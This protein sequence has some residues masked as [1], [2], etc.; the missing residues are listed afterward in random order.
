[1]PSKRRG[2]TL[3][4]YEGG[5]LLFFLLVIL[6][7]GGFVAVVFQF[8]RGADRPAAS[9]RPGVLSE[10]EIPGTEACMF[11]LGTKISP[12][13]RRYVG[14]ND[15][16]ATDDGLVRDLFGISGV[17]EVVIDQSMVMLHKVPSAR[18]ESIKPGAHEV[19][20]RHLHMH[21]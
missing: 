18:W 8:Y 13:N 20:N 12:H 2:K 11:Y 21:Q 16:P 1:M 9:E 3:R 19:I 15:I 5:N 10:A 17:T 4:G 14:I 7:L 6:V